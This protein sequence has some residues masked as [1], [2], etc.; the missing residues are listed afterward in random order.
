MPFSSAYALIQADMARVEQNLASLVREDSPWISSPMKHV[1]ERGGKRLRPALTL[2]SAQFYDYDIARLLPAATAVELLHT[3]SLV[4]DDVVDGASTRR[5]SSTVHARWDKSTA[6]LLGDYLFANAAD[7]ICNTG[8][9]RVIQ[10]FARTLMDMTSSQMEEAYSAF[11][12]SQVR[13]QYYRRIGGKTASLLAMAT[14][15][16]AIL[17]N[18]PEEVVVALGEYGYNLGLAFQVVDDILD[19]TGQEQE[20]GKPTGSDLSQGLLTLPVILLAERYPHESPLQEL[21]QARQA[22][23]RLHSVVQMVLN[24]TLID[25]C[26]GIVSGFCDRARQCLDKLPEREARPILRDLTDYVV[27]RRS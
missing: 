16:G 24:S 2:L 19:F 15:C 9:V 23:P 10:L 27:Q 6:I 4:H 20:L 25:E 7:F 14:Q 3:A 8:E 12:V 26:Y 18:S 5:G 17:S 1:L 13:E 11:N 21:F 22:G